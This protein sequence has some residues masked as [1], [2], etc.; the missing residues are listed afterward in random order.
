MLRRRLFHVRKSALLGKGTYARRTFRPAFRGIIVLDRRQ[1]RP[2]GTGLGLPASSALR[3]PRRSTRQVF[4]FS[5]KIAGIWRG[6]RGR[7]AGAHG[8]GTRHQRSF[9][10]Y[11]SN[12]QCDRQRGIFALRKTFF[13]RNADVFQEKMT[14]RGVKRPAVRVRWGFSDT[15]YVLYRSSISAVLL[16]YAVLRASKKSVLTR[17]AFAYWLTHSMPSGSCSNPG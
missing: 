9:R 16:A 3:K 17:F 8:R 4:E 7:W 13:R 10:V 12:S 5:R 14:R 6:G 15:P 11:S 1:P 2:K